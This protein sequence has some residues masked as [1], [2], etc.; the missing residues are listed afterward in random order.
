MATDVSRVSLNIPY[1]GNGTAFSR[2]NSAVE[3]DLLVR[4]AAQRLVRS[5]PANPR[6]LVGD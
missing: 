4:N 1:H 3:V 6:H 5:N 2:G